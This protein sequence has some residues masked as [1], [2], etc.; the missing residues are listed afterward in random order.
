[1]AE[2]DFEARTPAQL[3]KAASVTALVDL[4]NRRWLS[5]TNA[6]Q[7]SG[8]STAMIQAR[9]VMRG[10][11]V[12]GVHIDAELP[13][14]LN[15]AAAIASG[16]TAILRDAFV[17][18]SENLFIIKATEVPTLPPEM[19]A[20]IEAAVQAEIQ[21]Y[22]AIGAMPDTDQII[23]ATTRLLEAAEEDADDMA[24]AAAK[25]LGEKIKEMFQTNGWRG[26]FAEF[27]EDLAV[28][29]AAIIKNTSIVRKARKWVDGRLQ[30]VSAIER[31][32][33]RVAPWDFYVAPNAK[34]VQSAH[35]VIERRNCVS[36][37]D[38][39]NL[40]TDD[41]YDRE[42]ILK[43]LNQY[44]DGYAV[45]M[46]DGITA[47]IRKPDGLN[48]DITEYK[49]NGTYDILCMYGQVRGEQL[50]E[51]GVQVSDPLMSYEAELYVIGDCCIKANLNPDPAGR[52]PFAMASFY[53]IAG[54]AWGNSP[55]MRLFDTQRA[56][57]SAFISMVGD[58]SLAGLHIELDSSRLHADDLMEPESIRPRQVRMVKPN[59]MG[60]AGRAY[61]IESVHP[62][63]EAFRAAID[64][65]HAMSYE[66][67]G[68]PRLAF[69]DTN[70]AGTIGRT[71]SGIG[72][73]LN[74]SA[75][76]MK[77]VLRRLEENVIEV[78]V[79][80]EVDWIL[81]YEP[82]EGIS[83]DA[84]VQARGLTGLMEQEKDTDA[85]AWALQS[86]SPMVGKVDETGK[87]IVPGS[88]VKFV[89]AALLDAKGLPVD[90]IFPGYKDQQEFGVSKPPLLQSP[91][92]SD[93]MGG[94]Q[95]DG[96]NAPLAD[97]LDNANT[98]MGI[99]Q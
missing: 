67:I 63:A 9:R 79:Q 91:E 59:P 32:V 84:Q 51:M 99:P 41:R 4:V 6:R 87:A 8:M 28:Y 68:I 97:G 58:L 48:T 40:A 65:L 85:L 88:A 92:Q 76:L 49:N 60:N 27:L 11:P 26:A 66:L 10:E 69:G 20:A 93:T 19:Q 16:I 62:H 17:A 53:P 72:A 54:Q 3:K 13:I 90:K 95:L 81:H 24:Q 5:A 21:Q 46:D 83:G 61:N 73:V 15:V 64:H 78:V 55:L 1:M 36:A 96:R 18:A 35:Y 2:Y 56:I 25:E 71:S 74:Q 50:I 43:A 77:A 30:F 86:L 89:L 29:P 31:G 52:R 82:T 14:V 39:L 80:A 45:V 42:E 37:A 98:T 38:L 34:D 22:A 70:G 94:I 75:K 23:S 47:V 33:E 44:K 12:S 7:T 57:T